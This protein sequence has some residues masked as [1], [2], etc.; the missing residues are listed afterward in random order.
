MVA[1]A[2]FVTGCAQ[3][4]EI[5][6]ATRPPDA[7]ISIDGV[8]RGPGPVSEKFFFQDASDTKQI[9]AARVGYKDATFQLT[10][11][12]DRNV[13]QL[14]LRPL[15]KRVHITVGP[16][17]GIVSINGKLLSTEPVDSVVTDLDF[18]PDARNNLATYT[19]TAE[20]FGYQKAEQIVSYN[21]REP[22]YALELG[23]LRKDLN[24]TSKP[25]GAM[26]FVNGDRIGQ[27]PVTDPRHAFPI[28]PDRNEFVPVKIR[29][30]KAGFDAVEQTVAWD[31]GR[32]DY[33]F[34]LTAKSKT[35]RIK[36]DPPG[37]VVSIDGRELKSD[38]SG[39]AS[40][41]LSFP[42]VDDN[43]ELKTYTAIV[44]KKSDDSEW[45]PA[46]ITIAWDGGKT[47]YAV[48]LKEILTYPVALLTAL[49]E[50][51]DG[52]WQVLPK[53]V[54]SIAWKDTSEGPDRRPPVSLTALTPG[55]TID[56]LAVSPDG[57]KLIF[58]VLSRGKDATDF[59]SQMT[60]TTADGAGAT[61]FLTDGRSLELMPSFTPDGKRIVFSSN[62]A[63]RNLNVWSMP[64]TGEVGVTQ[65]TQGDSD[66]L[67]PSVD[68]DPKPRLF[69]Q[70]MV[71]TR[72]DPRLFMTQL[73]TTART[74][75]T[76]QG[77]MHPSVSPGADAVLFTAVNDKTGKRDIY[78]MA[79]TGGAAENLTNTPD[80]DEFHP[81]WHPA[82]GRVAFASDAGVD[83]DGRH[84]FDIW[85]MDLAS[86]T[87]PK[88]ITVNGSWDDHPIWDPAGGAIYF[89]SNRGGEWAVWKI[90]LN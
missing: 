43:G 5:T 85:T 1:V 33:Q 66:D 70:A 17:P 59:R 60:I 23:P 74:D 42:P 57:S 29:V 30:E 71:D 90:E 77:G 88:Q 39:A 83:P 16:V 76:Q 62:R 25:E 35:V 82:G 78:R 10:R 4:R 61:T 58:V 2:L 6:I 81:A 28:D 79:D 41:Q 64:V 86:P 36:T 40:V 19:V 20:R 46:K 13:L 49:A 89:R 37:A 38:A 21:D 48:T 72:P 84:N 14:D 65:L 54:Q 44:S 24:I 52:D 51:S 9:S 47:D 34:D 53:V 55:T 75:L 7:V 18:P 3:T 12:F 15:S 22:N 68:A 31:E 8:E 11:E 73:G 87:R 67:W 45:E 50:R 32:T 69:Y 63:G 80:V 56:S 27:T 26:V